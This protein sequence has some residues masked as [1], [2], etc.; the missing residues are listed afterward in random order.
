MKHA[1]LIH[2][3][4]ESRIAV[5]VADRSI[6]R[7]RGLLGRSALD[8]DRA[9]WLEPCNA[10][11]T[12]GMRFPIDVVFIDKRGCVLSVHCNVSRARMLVCW[13]ARST[14]EMR[15]HAAKALQ[16]EVGDSLEWRASA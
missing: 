12:F 7:M 2:R 9:L 8:A 11:H 1:S 5:E 14:L 4:E 3:G 10:V 13:R 15:A 16:I 6:E